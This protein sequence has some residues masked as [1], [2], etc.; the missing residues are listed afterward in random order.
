[1]V[2]YIDDSRV[3]DGHRSRMRDKLVAHGQR[4]FDTYEL[5][6]MLLYQ[7][8]PYRDTNPVAKNLLYAFGGLEGVL[9]ADRDELIKVSGI[10]EKVADYLILVGKLT[11][12]I[13]AEI[14]D[15]S[16]SCFSDYEKVGRFFASYFSGVEER[17]V[18]GLF[19]DNSMQLISMK[20]LYDL[21]YDSGG[22]KAKP[23]ID[24]AV[25]NHAVVVITAHNHPYGPFY[26]TQGDRATNSMITDSLNMVGIVHAEHFIVSG[27]CFAGLGSLKSFSVKL[28]QMPEVSNFIDS[29]D[30]YEGK[31]HRVNFSR[32]E[33]NELS[34]E[35]GYNRAAREY[36]A[37]LIGG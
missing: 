14:V 34:T 9:S 15:R 11:N 31:L 16:G 37:R 7:V 35:T 8:I 29:R 5:L 21:D 32:C 27:D 19:L 33:N 24:E 1:M 23:F 13:G 25:K 18:V 17:Q 3:H 30:K 28:S 2:K 10:G 22:V 12:V 26:P 20:K 4:I 36:F 6:E